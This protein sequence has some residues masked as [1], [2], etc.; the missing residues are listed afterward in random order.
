M[1]SIQIEALHGKRI[2]LT[3]ADSPIG[4][5]LMESLHHDRN[6][7]R[8]VALGAGPPPVAFERYSSSNDRRVTFTQIDLARP[9]STTSVFNSSLLKEAQVDSLIYVPAHGGPKNV[10][11]TALG[12]ASQ[13][14]EARLVLQ[15]ALELRG[16][17]TLVGL[18]S[19]FVYRLIPGNA[20]LF[21]EA[22]E[23]DLSQD[24]M[25]EIRG[26]IDADLLFQREFN[27]PALRVVLLRLPTVAGVR[28][29]VH[30]NPV[31][32]AAL[33]LSMRPMG[34]NPICALVSDKD[35]VRAT[36]LALHGTARGAFNIAGFETVPLSVLA[37]MIGRTNLPLPATF[38]SLA[39][40]LASVVG[41]GQF[42]ASRN[43]PQLRYGFTLD[44]ERARRELGFE[45]RYRIPHC[46]DP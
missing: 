10:P 32:D 45:A 36:M 41:G 44:P 16:L 40:R 18:G 25:T 30:F 3:H 39:S 23:L 1:T 33:T 4:T 28:G 19:A 12:E 7:E 20:N 31:L 35:V 9:R 38:V 13:T 22:S 5:L 42:P 27:N 26:W 43:A 14:V 34:F 24:V 15:H 37:N 2:V 8:I 17:R 46:C 11:R 6:V 29:E 21:N